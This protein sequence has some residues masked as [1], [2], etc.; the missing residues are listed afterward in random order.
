[1]NSES[2]GDDDRWNA[3]CVKDGAAHVALL[4]YHIANDDVACGR[5]ALTTTDYRFLVLVLTFVLF[6]H[7]L[8]INVKTLLC[9]RRCGCR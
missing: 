5:S 9:C 7:S 4:T 8:F 1:M 6:L 2:G 3:K